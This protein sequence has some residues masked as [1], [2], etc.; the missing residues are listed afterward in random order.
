[1]SW[2]A[3]LVAETMRDDL[4][5]R[6]RR[7]VHE[8]G[9]YKEGG[10]SAAQVHHLV[11]AANQIRSL[12]GVERYIREATTR[13]QP[14]DL[15]LAEPGRGE[16]WKKACPARYGE[17]WQFFGEKLQEEVRGVF[18]DARNKARSVGADG[19]QQQ[20]AAM[21]CLREFFGYL[22][23]YFVACKNGLSLPAT[24]A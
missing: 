15:T 20:T 23:W 13:S 4:A 17:G 6:A 19:V 11:M 12:P 3:V 16:A 2:K 7:L 18:A 8:T 24:Q 14:K 9:F 10:L 21:A 1:M 5:S 22:M